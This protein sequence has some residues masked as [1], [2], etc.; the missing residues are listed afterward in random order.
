VTNGDLGINPIGSASLAFY[1]RV[2]F[3]QYHPMVFPD[4]R[5]HPVYDL[6]DQSLHAK[7]ASAAPGWRS[8][9]MN[10]PRLKWELIRFAPNCWHFSM[11][12]TF[13]G[14]AGAFFASHISQEFSP[15]A[16]R[17]QHFHHDPMLP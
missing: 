8:A 16:F 10:W 13:S 1:W 4:Y 17:I 12:A 5:D 11:G 2:H 14:F 9:K 6:L 15:S 3:K 7:A